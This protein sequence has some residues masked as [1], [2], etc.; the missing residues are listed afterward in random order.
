M[1]M[2]ADMRATSVPL[3]TSTRPKTNLHQ[4]LS[5][6]QAFHELDFVLVERALWVFGKFVKSYPLAENSS[7]TG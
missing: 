6:M 7:S 1:I 2:L 3:A 5:F 4:Y